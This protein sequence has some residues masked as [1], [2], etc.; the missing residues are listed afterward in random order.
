MATD[1]TYEVKYTRLLQKPDYRF[2]SQLGLAYWQWIAHKHLPWWRIYE[3]HLNTLKQESKTDNH[4]I[5]KHR[6]PDTLLIEE[7]I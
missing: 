1:V 5:K 6:S 4:I 7:V 2:W 3:S